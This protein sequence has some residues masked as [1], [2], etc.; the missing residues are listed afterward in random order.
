MMTLANLRVAQQTVRNV[1]KI[2]FQKT[3]A[4]VAIKQKIITRYNKNQPTTIILSVIRKVIKLKVFFS[5]K[6][7]IS[8]K[9]VI[10]LVSS[11]QNNQQAFLQTVMSVLKIIFH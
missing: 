10:K 2:Q 8:S 1:Q 7:K 11:A 6:K 4:S 9:D 5:M 3:N